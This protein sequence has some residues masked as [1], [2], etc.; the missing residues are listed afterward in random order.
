MAHVLEVAMSRGAVLFFGSY[1][2]VH[3]LDYKR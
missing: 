3:S 2:S 1:V